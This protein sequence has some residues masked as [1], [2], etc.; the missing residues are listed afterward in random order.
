MVKK[1]LKK[2]YKSL[3][4][5]LLRYEKIPTLIFED[6]IAASKEVAKA[7]AKIIESKKGTCVLG[8]PTGSTPI[9][10]YEELIRLHEEEG[11]SF[12]I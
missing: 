12:N 4:K 6:A 10:I 1:S 11:L 2:H 8:L 5:H 7:I 9:F 3:D